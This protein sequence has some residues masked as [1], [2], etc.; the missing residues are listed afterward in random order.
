M[1]QFDSEPKMTNFHPKHS[2]SISNLLVL[3]LFLTSSQEPRK[4]S[5]KIPHSLFSQR[6]K[7]PWC[8]SLVWLV[9]FKCSRGESPVHLFSSICYHWGATKC[10]IISKLV[11]IYKTRGL[12][13]IQMG[14]EGDRKREL[15][16]YEDMQTSGSSLTPI[17]CSFTVPGVLTKD[18]LEKKKKKKYGEP[19]RKS[20]RPP[21][22]MPLFTF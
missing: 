6:T 4:R 12:R 22:F 21:S 2:K 7:W 20:R 13:S 3:L 16:E 8:V 1:Y 14:N 9:D 5:R 11:V 17:K 10:R 18:L 15:H 19:E